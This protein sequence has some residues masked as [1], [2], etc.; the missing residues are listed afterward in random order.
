M[1]LSGS[2]ST[3]SY[4]GRYVKLTWTA[5]QDISKN[6]ST[7][8]WTLAGAGNA[9]ASWYKAGPFQ[10]TINGETITI[11]ERITLYIG[12][13]VK[14]GTTTITHNSDGSKSFSISVKAAIY[15][16]SY[17]KSGS[18]TFTLNTIPRT[19]SFAR[20]G[21]ATMGNAQTITI[22]RAASA[23]T[24]KLYYTWSGTKTLI[25]SD[26][27]TSY[28]WTPP[29][30][31]AAKI[32]NATSA[33]CTLTCETYSGSTLIGSKTLSFTLSVPSSVV[34]TI[35]AVTLTEAVSGLAAQFGGFVDKKSKIKYAVTAAGAQ[36]STI[37][38]YSVSIAGQIFSKQTATTAAISIGAG[39][40]TGTVTVT[41][42]RGRSASKS[43]NYEVLAYSPPAFKLIT[44]DRCDENGVLNDDGHFV[45]FGVDVSISPVNNKNTALY[46]LEYKLTTEAD[47][48]YK[49][50]ERTTGTYSLKGSGV[51]PDV[52]F[53]TDVSYILRF[54]AIDYFTTTSPAIKTLIVTTA[55]PTF[56]VYRDGDGFGLGKVAE[57]K[58]V[59]DIG[60][61]TRLYGGLMPLVLP[62][63]ANLDDFKTAGFYTSGTT[64]EVKNYLN[65]PVSVASF[66]FEVTGA[67]S[68]GQIKQRL[69]FC[70]KQNS[71]VYERFYYGSAWGDW[72]CVGTYGALLWSGTWYMKETQTAELSEP[73]SKQA[74][75]I[76][77]VFQGY[78]TTNSTTNGD[79]HSFFIPKYL[80]VNTSAPSKHVFTMSRA[81]MEYIGAK[82]LFISDTAITGD[83]SNEYNGTNS[84]S[85][86]K[87]DNRAFVLS[88]V[89]GV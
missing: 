27:G 34:P 28:T 62:T 12:T 43:V 60:F 82:K 6:T 17:N 1:A 11:D 18:G 31:M 26:V 36:G 37:K 66:D 25:A 81:N 30:S 5:K 13:V 24:H 77:L 83:A 38:A 15:S 40:H 39:K 23:F 3:G 32:P 79:L 2:V 16:S 54:S 42:S 51:I 20:S 61:K 53:S 75:G 55:R 73:I 57:I 29:V 46:I 87:Y 70:S 68:T 21:T 74:N 50:L 59:C 47:S 48:E 35:S 41:D 9:E 80:I 7:I 44:A 86:I 71:R 10:I 64:E 85:G 33:S 65:C 67:G 84:I 72:V 19:S 58:G 4:E 49:E 22:T 56:D 69:T 63:N 52:E 76:V 8:S 89:I 45:S 88:Y 78:Q 14:T